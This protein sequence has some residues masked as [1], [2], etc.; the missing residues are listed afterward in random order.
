MGGRQGVRVEHMA[1]VPASTRPLFLGLA[2]K[3]FE[4]R[5]EN[6]YRRKTASCECLCLS[7]PLSLSFS[8]SSSVG[9]FNRETRN[10]KSAGTKSAKLR[11]IL[12][13]DSILLLFLRKCV[14]IP[15][16]MSYVK[17]S[18]T[19][20]RFPSYPRRTYIRVL[21]DVNTWEKEKGAAYRLLS[22][23]RRIHEIRQRDDPCLRNYPVAVKLTGFRYRH[24]I[25]SLIRH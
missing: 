22:F 11:P 2:G 20:S 15:T 5:V 3:R 24:C 9:W 13:V 25:P 8:I 23:V 6:V 21:K 18:P 19:F 4:A 17:L 12:V 7:S 14:D 10:E 16:V 1:S